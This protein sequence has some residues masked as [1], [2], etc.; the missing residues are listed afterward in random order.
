MD[1]PGESR[2]AT[3]DGIK[4]HYLTA[5]EGVPLLL[6]HGL[7]ASVATWRD[8]IG[9]LSK[10]FQVYAL[11]YPGHGDSGKPR[12]M[13]YAPS[14]IAHFVRRFAEALNLDRMAMI[15]NSVGG[16]IGMML[17][18]G[19][20]DLVSSLVLVGSA[21]LGREVSFFMRLVSVPGLG[22][23][24]AG[25]RVDWT[26]LMLRTVFYDRGFI[27]QELTDEMGR[28]RRMPGAREAVLKAIRNGVDLGGVRKEYVLVDQ[29]KRLDIPLMLVWG[30]QDRVLPVS[31]AYR[32]Q[33]VVP[34]AQLHILDRCGHWPHMEKASE[35]NS[36]AMRF[37]SD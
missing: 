21:S 26:G 14:T 1:L 19:K 15:G 31:H 5:G 12:D 22:E 13:D 9:P 4:A 8:N 27:T 33:E 7:G 17:A 36:L 24:L 32:A 29:L 10:A 34:N 30:R 37:L 2:Y 20:P 28:T 11:D 18:L 16:A 25:P 6:L 23:L 3:V 35:F